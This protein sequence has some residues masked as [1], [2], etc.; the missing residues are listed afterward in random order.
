MMSMPK[1]ITSEGM[2]DFVQTGDPTSNIAR[3]GPKGAQ[4]NPN[5]QAAQ[6]VAATPPPLPPT[7][8]VAA[9]ATPQE[10]PERDIEQDDDWKKYAD[11]PM[12]ERIKKV[13]GKKH[14]EMMTAREE[15]AELERL[16]EQQYN[17]AIMAEKRLREIESGQAQPVAATPPP[18]PPEDKAPDQNDPKYRN[19]KGEF[20]WVTY[21]RD[22]ADHSAK[23]A[24]S[25]FQQEQQKEANERAATQ[26]KIAYEARLEE[27][28]KLHPDFDQ[29]V[30]SADIHTH[31]AVL[32]YV[33]FDSKVP[34]QIA[35]HL[36]KNPEFL[37]QINSMSAT[38]AVAEIGALAKTFEKPQGNG[39]TAPPVVATPRS[40]GAPP[41]ITP[42]DT[43]S[44]GTVNVDPSKMSF[45]ELR[46]FERQRAAKGRH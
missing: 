40:S 35:Y 12:P 18:A 37:R 6:P 32:D 39:A 11:L 20:D 34:G 27:A 2:S 25:K 8:D 13:V 42:L 36:A 23:Q 17:R 24:V 30:P 15:N 44:S 31:R 28:K 26:A 46:K 14:F 9:P 33:F 41:P 16:A 29:V 38:A 4:A 1:V 22:T 7:L 5:K 21:T 3:K 10:P 19:D 45:Q 43:S